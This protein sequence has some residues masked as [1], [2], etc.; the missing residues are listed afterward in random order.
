[1]KINHILIITLFFSG[2][3]SESSQA[4][5]NTFDKAQMSG[6][7]TESVDTSIACDS[8]NLHNSFEFSADGKTLTFKLDRPWKIANDKEVSQY[9]A[10]II[11]ESQ[12]SLTIEYF[13]TEGLPEDYPKAWDIVFVADGVYRWKASNWPDSKVNSVVGIRCSK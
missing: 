1:M 4:K 7:W 8:K 9:S 10:K 2:C 12:N 5:P 6:V 11:K 3:T 13:D